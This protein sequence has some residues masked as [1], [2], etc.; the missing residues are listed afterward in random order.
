MFK[1][2]GVFF[3]SCGVFCN[4]MQYFTVSDWAGVVSAMGQC[5]CSSNHDSLLCIMFLETCM[6]VVSIQARCS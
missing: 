6:V 1:I 5:V 2:V 4:V 3:I